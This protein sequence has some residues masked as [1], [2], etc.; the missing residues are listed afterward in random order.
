MLTWDDVA[1]SL[2]H[3]RRRRR[4]HRR[5]RRRK[6]K[7]MYLLRG[8]PGAGK[9]HYSRSRLKEALRRSPTA[10]DVRRHVLSTDNYFTT[11]DGKYVFD[12]EKL[13]VNHHKNQQEAKKC[14]RRGVTPLFIDNTNIEAAHMVPYVKLADESNYDVQVVNMRDYVTKSNPIWDDVTKINRKLLLDRA[15]ERSGDGSGKSIPPEVIAGMCDR[16]EQIPDLTL[17]DLYQAMNVPDPVAKVGDTV[18]GMDGSQWGTIIQGLW[19]LDNG[20]TL[21]MNNENATWR[22]DS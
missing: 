9:S 3:G 7:I 18:A 2:E 1:M 16:Y 14:M 22:V 8:P 20:S 4:R 10:Q 6:I 19:K 5:H 13:S 21:Q 17:E 15:T 12:P 11:P